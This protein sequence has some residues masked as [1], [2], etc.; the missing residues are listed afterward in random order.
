MGG[1]A[2]TIGWE[3]GG[4]AMYLDGT[5]LWV[6]RRSFEAVDAIDTSTLRLIRS[7]PTMPVVDPVSVTK[8]AG[9]IWL[10]GA[11]G[12]LEALDPVTG[13]TTPSWDDGPIGTGGAGGAGGILTA[14]PGNGNWM[15]ESDDGPAPS[16]VTLLDVSSG[17]APEVGQGQLD[18]ELLRTGHVQAGRQ[19][20][21][22][23]RR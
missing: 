15:L 20:V 5:T 6:V 21:L 13:F 10:A 7:Y 12:G 16:T 9:P 18:V 14:V 11:A 23:P 17:D 22:V 2:A 1:I 3:I 19:C 4:G 8:V